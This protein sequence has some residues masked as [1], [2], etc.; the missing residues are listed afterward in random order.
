VNESDLG[1]LLSEGARK[2]SV[3]GAAV[4]ILRDGRT[5]TACCGVADVT[6]RIPVDAETC[7]SAGSLTK[8]MVAT[9]IAWL[10]EAGRLSLDDPIGAHVPELRRTGWATGAT[11]RDLLANR[12]GLPL[13]AGLE[14]GFEDHLDRDDAA[15]SRLVAEIPVGQPAASF[16][17]YTNVGW[18]LLGRAIEVSTGVAWEEA[19]RRQLFERAAMRG[20]GFAG[21]PA[22]T[23]RATGHDV[24]AGGPV[25]VAPMTGRAYG[26]AGTTVL[27]TVDDLLRFAA[28][29]LADR[30]LAALRS[31]HADVSIHAWLDSW[32]LGWARFNWDGGGVW[33]W[34]GLIGGERSF[35][36]IVPEHR[37]ALVLMTNSSTG[38]ALYR[39]LFAELMESLFGIKFPPLGLEPSPTAV[40]DLFRFTGLYGWPDQRFSVE[41]T[42]KGLL[43]TGEGKQIEALPINERTFLV[44][45]LDPDNPTITFGAFD[46]AGRPWVLY[47]MLWGL[48][49]LEPLDNGR[50]T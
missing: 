45:P 36:R 8:S 2:H 35:L 5:T 43:I 18:C 12:S 22:P 32:C 34:D 10:V 46:G 9:V 7:F 4:G 37:A 23:T 47:R 30:S 26:P 19:M 48:P 50:D 42:E 31:V 39:E 28:V 1:A 25:P 14:F 41:A 6:S 38:R 27:S 33:G 21:D 11:L 40:A 20:T 49:R 3:P 15:L 24:N 29:H 44:D 13:S 16:W 17:S